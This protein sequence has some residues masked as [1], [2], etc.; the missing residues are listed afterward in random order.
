MWVIKHLYGV[1]MIFKKIYM[2]CY[3]CKFRGGVIGS[4]HSSCKVISETKTENSSLLELM[5]STH[6]VRMTDGDRDLV[7]LNPHGISNGWANW[8]LDFDPV[9]VKSCKFYTLK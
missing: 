9:W 7:E 5:L 8:P 6:Q 3:N 1:L 4:A 2:D